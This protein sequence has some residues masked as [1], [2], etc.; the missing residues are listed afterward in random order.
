[1]PRI[2]A[3]NV[4]YLKYRHRRGINNKSWG[5]LIKFGSDLHTK[6]FTAILA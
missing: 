3:V 2:I 6:Q 1:M 5:S 4:F